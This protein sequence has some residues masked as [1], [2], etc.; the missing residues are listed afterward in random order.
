MYI[1]T[2]LKSLFDIY[3]HSEV[4]TIDQTGFKAAG[5]GSVFKLR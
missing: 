3:V 4:L 2:Q 1:K 5:R